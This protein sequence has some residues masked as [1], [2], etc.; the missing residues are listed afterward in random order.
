M[1]FSLTYIFIGITVIVSIY[2]FNHP[3]MT[4]RW[5]FNPWLI[6]RRRQYDRFITSGFIHKDY[7]HLFFNMISFYFFGPVVEDTFHFAFGAMGSLYF[8]LF[9]LLAI[10]VSDIP[11]YFKNRHHPAYNALGASGGV[12]AVIF[13]SILFAPTSNICFY[14]VLCFPGFILGALYIIYSYTMGR[15]AGD[16]INHDAHLYGALFGIAF[17][18]VLYPDSIAMFLHQLAQW[19]MF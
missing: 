12:S 4:A 2:A 1:E 9:Y 15:K 14:F 13:A 7:T 18:I 6:E 11:S 10:V 19:R 17:C 8:V 3:E 5:M 16:H